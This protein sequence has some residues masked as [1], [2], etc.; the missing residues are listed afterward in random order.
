VIPG[1]EPSPSGDPAL[2]APG[3]FRGHPRRYVAWQL[4][5]LAIAALVAYAIWRSYQNP[6]LLLDLSSWRLC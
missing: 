6:D 2:R 3:V 1:F 4:V 5:K